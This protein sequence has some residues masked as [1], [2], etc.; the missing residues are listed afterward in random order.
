MA[1][2]PWWVEPTTTC[3]LQYLR[4]F[5]W[6]LAILTSQCND[7]SEKEEEWLLRE[8]AFLTNICCGIIL[9]I[10]QRPKFITAGIKRQLLEISYVRVAD[11]SN[12]NE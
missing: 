8:G 12:W 4:I 10:K 7:I 3:K 11:I 2:G 5:A 6:N 9:S 1:N